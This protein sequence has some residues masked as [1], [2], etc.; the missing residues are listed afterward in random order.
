[1]HAPEDPALMDTLAE[2]GIPI[3]SNLTSNVQTSTV[4]D[5]ASHPLKQF[6]IKGIHA[7]INTDDPGIS[8]IDLDHELTV[9]APLAGLTSND[10]QQARWNSL[11]AAFLSTGEKERIRKKYKTEA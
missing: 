6:L 8:S 9:A 2:K 1:V 3:E 10:I 7:T 5:Y 11:D 4:P